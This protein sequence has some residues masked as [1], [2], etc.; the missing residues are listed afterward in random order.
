MTKKRGKQ[1]EKERRKKNNMGRERGR[2]TIKWAHTHTHVRRPG[3]GQKHACR[4]VFPSH[5][6]VTDP[7]HELGRGRWLPMGSGGRMSPPTQDHLPSNPTEALRIVRSPP[8]R[9]PGLCRKRAR[10]SAAPW[11]RVG[12][13]CSS[14]GRASFFPNWHLVLRWSMFSGIGPTSVETATLRWLG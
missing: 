4:S 5:H 7:D 14:S 9:R 10:L 3:G 1:S 6:G 13:R 12:N 2:E 8:S 11:P